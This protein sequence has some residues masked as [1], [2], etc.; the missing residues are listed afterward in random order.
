MSGW[1]NKTNSDFSKYRAA[2]RLRF[3][4]QKYFSNRRANHPETVSM[5]RIFL[6]DGKDCRSGTKTTFRATSDRI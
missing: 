1:L 3:L 6:S 4:L 2:E 5:A